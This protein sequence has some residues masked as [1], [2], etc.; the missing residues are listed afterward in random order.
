MGNIDELVRILRGKREIEQAIEDHGVEVPDND[1]VDDY[2]TYVRQIRTAPESIDW[3][4]ITGDI[5]DQEDLILLLSELNQFRYEVAESTDAIDEPQGNVLYLIGP[6]GDGEDQYEEYVYYQE[7]FVKIGDLSIDLSGKADIVDDAVEDNFASFDSNGNLKD[8]G[9][10]ASD[11]LTEH[12]D[13]SDKADKDEDAVEGNFAAFD[14]SGN[15][16]DSGHKHSDYLTSHQ[17][18]STKADKV[19]NA[20]SGNFAGLDSNGNITDSGKKASDFLT[21]HQ[22]ITGKADKDEDAVEG[23]FAAFDANGNPVDSGSKASDFATAAQ[24]ALAATAYQKPSSGIPAADLASGVIPTVHNV[25]SGGTSGQVLAKASGTDYDLEWATPSSGGSSIT[26]DSA[27]SDSSENPVQN[28]VIYSALA[29]LA[30]SLGVGFYIGTSTSWG[31]TASN[32]YLRSNYFANSEVPQRK[33]DLVYST[34]TK[35]LHQCGTLTWDEGQNCNKTT[36]TFIF[37]IPTVPTISTDISTDATSDVKTTSPKAVKTFVEGKGYGT[38]TKPANGIPASDLEAGVIPSVPVTDVTVGGTSVV[39][40]GTAAVPA[41]PDAVEAN[42]TVPSGTTPTALQNVKVGNSYYSVSTAAALND[43][44]DVNA[45][46]PSDGDVLTYD[47]AT[48]KWVA[49]TPSGGGA[50]LSTDVVTD[51][52]DNT[53]ASTPKSV[54]DFVKPASQNTMPAGGLLPGVLYN[55]GVLTGSVTIDLATPADASVANE[56]A[57]TFYTSTTAPTITWPSGIL[58]WAGNCIE[59]YA[60]NIKASKFYEVSILNGIGAIMEVE[61]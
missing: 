1:R 2:D 48:G 31:T 24:G 37:T 33:G 54:Y 34:G 26:V 41:I 32:C 15:P 55:L 21:S 40:S 8:S 14:S 23:N 10:A 7:E 42:P 38:Y 30:A 35:N 47:N 51:K 61:V 16:V 50:V 4:N 58:G 52:A 19:G 25:P 17:D 57:F 56:Y 44:T 11:F 22:D 46:S 60:P 28:K 39:S 29:N 12:Q 6:S 53:K 49:D 9:Y 5:T 18:I 3:G 20:T 36:P 13:I 59:N 45:G 27:M 43:L